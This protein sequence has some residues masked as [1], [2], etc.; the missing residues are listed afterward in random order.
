MLESKRQPQLLLTLREA[1]RDAETPL[2]R[3]DAMLHPWVAFAI[4]PVFALVSGRVAAW[5]MAAAIARPVNLGIM[6]GLVLGKPLGVTLTALGLTASG[7]A[8]RLAGVGWR[9]LLGAGCLAGI[10]FTMSI[11]IT[12]LAFSDPAVKDSAKLGILTASL[13]S[14]LAA[15]P[16]C[17]F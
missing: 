13:V 15:G 1:C 6:F 10:G 8:P 12:E 14:A 4:M 9:H 7:I 2:Q 11:F 16:C 17:A 5:D 3:L